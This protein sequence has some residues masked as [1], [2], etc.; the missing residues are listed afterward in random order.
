MS[1]NVN[2][3][4]FAIEGGMR[5]YA[6]GKQVYVEK[7][8]ARPMPLPMP[9]SSGGINHVSAS[10]W[11][12]GE[13]GRTVVQ[14]N[15]KIAALLD[16]TDLNPS[17]KEELVELYIAAF[18]QYEPELPDEFRFASGPRIDE[19]QTFI[20]VRQWSNAEASEKITA[21][22]RIAGTLVNISID[23][24]LQTPGAISGN[25]PEGR[26]LRAFLEAI[27][28]KDFAD[29]PV[30]YLAGSLLTAIVEAVKLEPRLIGNN[31]TTEKLVRNITA[32]LSTS[33]SIYLKDLPTQEQ[34]QR[35]EWLQLIAYSMVKGTAETVL[36]NPQK[37]LGVS[38]TEG[39]VIN[40]VGG[41]VADLLIGN[42]DNRRLQFAKL[43]SGNGLE[44][45]IKASLNAV[46]DNPDILKIGK[47]G[48]KSVLIEVADEL[49][50]IPELFTQDIYPELVKLLLEKSSANL[51]LV[52]D[53][54]ENN[55]KKHLLV[56]ANSELM[57]QLSAKRG[58]AK[59]KPDLTRAQA[60]AIAEVA[61]DEVIDNPFW[62]KQMT[63]VGGAGEKPL[64][65]AVSA[66]LNSFAMVERGRFNN[67]TI[68]AALK[69]G[70]SAGAKEISLLKKAP[71]AAAGD[72]RVVIT[73]AMDAIFNGVLDGNSNARSQW[74][75]ACNSK[76][77]VAIEVVLE[78]LAQVAVEKGIKLAQILKIE[79][80]ICDWIDRDLSTESV[81]KEIRAEL[82]AA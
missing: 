7:T 71:Q 52:W 37:I 41:S 66:V 62:V 54:N 10:R 11:F 38:Q 57:K 16:R 60:L 36:T 79:T 17:E 33:A 61:F 44:T 18:L 23:Y 69:A 46:T 32:S 77:S 45:V 29:T 43:L 58:V 3:V 50:L 42:D 34:R 59:W 48:L 5:L 78:Q 53:I 27:D 15:S 22:Q 76:I 65:V 24:F 74:R 80:S 81:A 12:S 70:I 40:E 56:I 35:G 19:L 39:V 63:G 49:E 82:L 26:A 67:E 28:N 51:S 64:G 13:T 6:A 8:L 4:M 72:A 47:D 75:Q 68:L 25:K 2:T 20:N 55:P 1:A 9:S 31:E 73:S 30:E 14:K 21:L